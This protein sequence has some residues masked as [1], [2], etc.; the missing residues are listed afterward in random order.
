MITK[1]QYFSLDELVCEDVLNTYGER[2]WSFFDQRLLI[3]LDTIRDRIGK[4]IFVNDWLIHGS[5][6]Q[7]GLR[8]LRCD[9]VKAKCLSGEM[10]MSAHMLGKAADFDI[11]GLVASEV[12]AWIIKNKNAWPYHIR[13]EDGVSWVHLDTFDFSDEKVVLFNK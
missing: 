13:L 1:P 4:P 8:C 5:Y 2:A 11:V 7:R 6:S 12:R 10:Y 3:T 9:L